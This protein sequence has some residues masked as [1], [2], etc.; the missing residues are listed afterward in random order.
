MSAL[1]SDEAEQAV[2]GGLM[3]DNG[4]WERVVGR[5]READFHRREHRAIFGVIAGL[6]N[7]GRPMDAVTVGEALERS[8]SLD[9]AGGL[10]FLGQLVKDTPSAANVGSYADVVRDKARRREFQ[11]LMT[12]G[13]ELAGTAEDLGVAATEIG[14]RL[15]QVALRGA[16]RA[17]TLR[18]ATSGALDYL[19]GLANGECQGIPTGFPLLDRFTGGL[20]PGQLVIL[21]ARPAC[22]KTSLAMQIA[23][24]AAGRGYPV[25]VMSLEMTARELA[26]RGIAQH[27][28]LNGGRLLRGDD[29]EVR[30]AAR[31]L[32]ASRFADL[33]VYID[34]DTYDLQ[35]LTARV[36]Q[37]RRVDRLSLAIVDHIG[38]IVGRSRNINRNEWVG[39]V[40]RR[41]KQLAKRLGI[42]ILALSQL[43]RASTREN[44]EPSLADLRDSGHIEHDADVVLLLYPD[45]EQEGSQATVPVKVILAKNRNGRAGCMPYPYLFDGSR[46]A[47]Y[48]QGPLARSA[49]TR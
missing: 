20:Q 3:L 22:G 25:G 8:G 18:D 11:D 39:I 30:K 46:F 40:S 24:H 12:R 36:S 10:A 4:Q 38:L 34:E 31:E 15:D 49:Q 19:D 6:A 33:P 32:P 5:L 23:L 48:E 7:A 35:A 2:L 45:Q 28:G 47:F 41:L 21:A 42:P 14:E 16:G 26:S 37:W 17:V 27:L 1:F 13:I 29:A 43:N 44:R 9:A